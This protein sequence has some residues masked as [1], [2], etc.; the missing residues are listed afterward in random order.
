MCSW[1]WASLT[2]ETC[3]AGLKRSINGICCILLVAYIVVLMKRSLTNIKLLDTGSTKGLFYR[4]GKKMFGIKR[5]QPH[6]FSHLGR[7]ACCSAPNSRPPATKALHT[8]RGNNTSIVPSSWWWAYKCP[9]H[10]DQIISAIKHSVASSL[11]S[12]LRLYYDARTNI[13]K[14][15]LNSFTLQRVPFPLPCK[16]LLDRCEINC[17]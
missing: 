9:K 11:Y 12:S 8:I 5:L 6:N 14:I 17:K 2:P 1:G 15:Y 13:H 7:I 4:Q 3:R 10:V 16:E